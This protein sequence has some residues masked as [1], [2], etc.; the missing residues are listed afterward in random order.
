VSIKP[1][2]RLLHYRIVDML[3]AGG[4][5]EVYLAEDTRLGRQVAIKVLPEQFFGDSHAQE[6]FQREARAASALNHPHI[7]TIYDVGEVDQHPFMVMELLK[8]QTL[9]DR[10]LSSNFSKEEL[11]GIAVQIADALATAHAGGIVHRDIKPANIFI[12]ERGDAKVLDFGLA[13]LSRGETAEADTRTQTVAREDLTRPGTTLGTIAYMSPEQVLGSAIDGRSDL[14]SFGVVLYEMATGKVPF[15]GDTLGSIFDQIIHRA[16]EPPVN[17]NPEL[18]QALE[19]VISRCLQKD[20]QARPAS[21]DEVRDA[22]QHALDELR[23]VGAPTTARAGKLR[24]LGVVAVVVLVAAGSAFWYLQRERRARQ[25]RDTVPEIRRL[26]EHGEDASIM[27][28]FRLATKVE[29]YLED[30]PEFQALRATIA[31]DVEIVTEPPGAIVYVKPYAQPDAEWEQ[32]GETPIEAYR[33]PLVFTRWKVEKDGYETVTDVRIPG[34]YG[35]ERQVFVPE[36]LRWTLTETGSARAGMVRIPENELPAFWI[37][38]YEV[39]NRQF[40]AFVDAGG[41]RNPEFWNLEFVDGEG[42]VARAE[43]LARFVDRTGLPGPSIWEGGEYPTGRDDY[44][45]TGVSWYEAAAF[46]AFAGK[47]LPTLQHWKD[48]TGH[49]ID[50]SQWNFFAKL[51]P[52]SN[53]DGEAPLPVGASQAVTPLGALDMAGN[54]REWCWNASEI[55]RCLRGGAWN[56]QPYMFGNITQAR[57]FDRNE[58]NG[59]RCVLYDDRGAIDAA[60]FEPLRPDAVRDL[61]NETPVSDEVFQAYRAYYTYDPSP[62]DAVV[63]A[64]EEKTD[65]I[66]EHITFNAAYGEERVPVELM[67]PKI[68]EPPYQVVV[69]FSGDGAADAPPLDDLDGRGEFELYLEFMLKTGRAVAYVAYQGTHGRTESRPD[70]WDGETRSYADFR[71]QQ[72]QD[73]LRTGDYLETRSDI[74]A[75]RIAFYGLS[76]GGVELNLVLALDDRYKTAIAAVGGM[77]TYPRRPEIDHIHFAPRVTAPVLMLNGRFD[78][79][80]PYET[81]ARP[82]YELLG[83]PAEHKKQVVYDNDHFLDRKE[84]VS[85]ILPW[86]DTYLGPVDLAQR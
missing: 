65:W 61:L 79:A 60:A 44:P 11:L 84:L 72:V 20:R 71:I 46:A 16:P 4:M 85:E 13:K 30:D 37:D 1:G 18:P 56:D 67:L 9:R 51:A 68:A 24:M 5:G 10:M 52:L 39:T 58:K 77:T 7:C 35:A 32:I 62:L 21:A 80:L 42:V 41:Y 73:F 64:S 25:A 33:G 15:A 17:L 57:A 38:K 76:R 6:R 78:L 26:V 2:S 3:G 19:T 82:M 27:E 66:R 54:V 43:A 50:L 86:L 14:F 36:T 40:K 83:T 23:G 74:D 69:Y 53:F 45:V 70:N 48:A 49:F 34:E 81:S 12:T 47:S 75:E 55:G 22:L 31:T 28:A 59:F 8:G 29:G 63:E